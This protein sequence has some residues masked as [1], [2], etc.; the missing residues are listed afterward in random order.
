MATANE[1]LPHAVCYLWDRRLLGLHAVTD[2]LIG[3]SYVAIS[4]TLGY[5]VYRARRDI[6]FHWMLLAFGGFIIACGAT[7]FME[8]WTLWAPH[9]WLAGSVKVVTAV[10]SVATAVV[11]PSLVPQALALVRAAKQTSEQAQRLRSSEARFRALLESAPD[12]IV[13]A[14]E[15]GRILLVN[16]QAE[17]LFGYAPADLVGQPV[18]T[19]LPDRVRD[20]H[21]GHRAGYAADPRTRPMGVGLALAG[22]R[23]D[24]TEFPA[25]ISLSPLRTEQGLLVTT[26]IRDITERKRAEAQRTELIREQAARA[27]AEAANRAKDEFLATLSHELRTPLNAVYGWARMLNGG[28]LDATGSARA[29]E[30]IE[31]NAFAQVQLIDDLLDVS[32]IVTGKMRIEVRPVDLAGVVDTAVDAVRLAAGAKQIQ[33]HREL[34]P[35]V[36]AVSGDADRLR[37][38]VSNL[39]SN[40][41]KFTPRGGRIE[42]RLERRAGHARIVVRDNGPGIASDL[43]PHLFERFRQ[44]D[45]SSSRLH[46]GLGIGLALVRHLTELHGGTV[47]AERS[48]ADGGATFV[49]ELPLAVTPPESPGRH[50]PRGPADGGPRL[51]GVR[52]L[53]VDDD[54][55]S[56]ELAHTALALRGAAVTTASSVPD[57]MRAL[58]ES[59]ADVILADI[60]MP[61]EDGYDLVRRVRGLPSERLRRVPVIALTAYGRP[62]DE[63]RSLAAGFQLHLSKPIDPARLAAV[64]ASAAHRD[65]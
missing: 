63:R 18:E 55:D 42:V 1:F 25:E 30:V 4:L 49:V 32:R 56:L 53:V 8:V 34:E 21:V 52:V 7:H 28:S 27:E 17:A 15:R 13:I 40:A 54:P 19:L 24:G 59:S 26:V 20:L 31:R 60:E 36:P 38:V 50:Q 61:G 47:R 41:V 51:D 48:G 44:A 2:L 64:V 57:A 46:G 37:Q 3:A 22:R 58:D 35:G 65:A 16:Q 6:P 14:D 9:Y 62:E 39:L 33:L 43:L 10:A 45:S 29:V 12:P 5:L 11:L 23:R